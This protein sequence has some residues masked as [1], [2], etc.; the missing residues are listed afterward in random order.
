MVVQCFV[1]LP[2]RITTKKK[3]KLVHH[4]VLMVV[5]AINYGLV[6]TPAADEK[7]L[8]KVSKVCKKRLLLS[9]NNAVAQNERIFSGQKS[10]GKISI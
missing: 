5:G 10:F 8:E 3:V 4:N 7:T 9:H 6:C 2:N 1:V